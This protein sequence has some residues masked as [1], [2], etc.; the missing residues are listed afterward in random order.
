MPSGMMMFW[1]LPPEQA[2]GTVTVAVTV[3][4]VAAWLPVVNLKLYP[5]ET[6]SPG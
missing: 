6:Q 1:T 3:Y 5:P 4:W 2:T